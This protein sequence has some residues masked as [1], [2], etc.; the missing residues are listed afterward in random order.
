MQWLKRFARDAQGSTFVIVAMA[1]LALTGAVG[2]AVDAGRGF[3]VQTRLQNAM[4]AAGLAA[5]ASGSADTAVLSS[6]VNKYV[7]LNFAGG[8]LGATITATTTSLSQ[9]QMTITVSSSATV[10]TSVM[11]VFGRTTMNIQ[12]VTA[13]RRATRGL[14]LALVLDVTGSMC[15]PCTKL[16]AL[17]DAANDLLDVL[18]GTSAVGEDL[19]VG[20]VP[21]SQ[22]VNI[23]NTRTGWL[24][25]PASSFFWGPAPNSWGG[26]V[27]SRW[28]G[29]DV[30]VATPATDP[31]EPYNYPD[32][33]GNDWIVP[34]TTT[35][36]ICNNSS[37]CTCANYGPCS[38]TTV[39]DTTTCITCTGS[40]S[41]RRCRRSVTTPQYFI[42]STR[43]PNLYCPATPVTPLTNTKATLNTAINALVASGGT[44]IP[45]GLVWGWRLIDENW[46][47]VWGG[48]MD[49]NGLPL[50]Y[51]TPLMDKAV[52]LMTDGRNTMYT[53]D[54]NRTSYGYLSQG[55][56]GTTSSTSVAETNLNNK[57]SAVCTAMKAQ[58]VYVYTVLFMESD[59]NIKTLLRNCA[60]K[61]EYF[62]DT[63]TGA[64]LQ[65]AFQTIGASLANL[66]ISR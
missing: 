41:T 27:D 9:D 46:R 61:P 18:F 26:C 7:A 63:S 12:A 45:V 34:Q 38:C 25:P 43:G 30:T 3:I 37:S 54:I 22:T 24:S 52:V 14:E 64:D 17:K 33:A 53:D 10:P 19:W 16:T 42:D 8:N 36:T 65:T 50:N 35:T 44:H 58:G 60:T 4:D 15:Q 1:T 23:G 29:N 57:L 40:G 48:S 49:T 66:R 11:R 31:F 51:N 47:N 39:G 59:A 6:I 13:V 56:L 28:D 62:F 55:R 32:G 20:I 21:F 5:G 2:A